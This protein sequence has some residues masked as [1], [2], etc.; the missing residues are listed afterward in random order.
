MN[1]SK[2]NKLTPAQQDKYLMN[3]ENTPCK[4]PANIDFDNVVVE[5]PTK[6]EIY[7]NAAKNCKS[8]NGTG[9]IF[10]GDSVYG[11]SHGLSIED[12]TFNGLIH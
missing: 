6:E 5:S 3:E 12:R 7:K 1:Q 2:F 8:C 10:W 11:C 9:Q 4:M